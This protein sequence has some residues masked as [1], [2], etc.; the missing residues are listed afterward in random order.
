MGNVADVAELNPAHQIEWQIENA[1]EGMV[2]RGRRFNQV[3]L[4]TSVH[5][6]LD[7]TIEERDTGDVY[8]HGRLGALQIHLAVDVAVGQ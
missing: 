5:A 1:R 2:H 3:A 4:A 6:D 8:G 7:P